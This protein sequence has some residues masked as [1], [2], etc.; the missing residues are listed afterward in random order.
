MCLHEALLMTSTGQKLDKSTLATCRDRLDRAQ[1]DELGYMSTRPAWSRSARGSV[2]Q[3]VLF[4]SQIVLFGIIV[5]QFT[6]LYKSY[7]LATAAICVEA[8]VVNRAGS[9]SSSS[10]DIPQYYQTKPELYPGMKHR[11]A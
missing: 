10:S 3:Q 6:M 9:S 2:S 1:E 4:W 8:A 5:V 11:L 7:F